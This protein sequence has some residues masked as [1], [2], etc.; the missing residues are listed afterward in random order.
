MKVLSIGN[1]FSQDAQAYLPKLAIA[2]GKELLLGNLYLPGASI[3]D[4]YRNYIDE[5]EVYTYENY[6]PGETEAYK[7]DGIALHEAVEDEDWDVITL[8]QCSKLSG[9]KESYT[10][11]L[12]EVAAYC[13]MMHP[14]AKIMLHQ[15]WAYEKGCP[16]PEFKENY[17]RDQDKMYSMLTECYAETARE[18]EI[19]IIIPTG[20][21]WQ[22]A[23]QTKIGDRL[24]RDGYH[25]N[26]L[27][28]FLGS[29]CFYEMIFGESAVDNPFVLPEFDE[30]VSNLLKVCAHIACEE[31]IIKHQ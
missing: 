18:A 6:L 25:G 10:P 22:T 7:P 19:D 28:Q 20:R 12:A 14:D 9:I 13:R 1:S 4:H 15:T 27:G 29:C 31:G 2:G 30:N 5:E 23:R 17:D 24:T 8:Q 26:E 11:Y 16:L 3:E 21:A